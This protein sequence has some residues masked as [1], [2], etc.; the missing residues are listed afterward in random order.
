MIEVASDDDSVSD[1]FDSS[2]KEGRLRTDD[3]GELLLMHSSLRVPER[4]QPG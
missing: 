1:K 2:L 3:S 4:R